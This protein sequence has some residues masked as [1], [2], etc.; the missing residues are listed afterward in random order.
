VPEFP[1][2]LVLEFP[3]A[4]SLSGW[5]KKTVTIGTISY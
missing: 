1:E 5:M 2:K 3:E 4:A